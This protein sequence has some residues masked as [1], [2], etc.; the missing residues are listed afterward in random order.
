[1][2]VE[3]FYDCTLYKCDCREI[4][5]TAVYDCIVTDPVW[6]NVPAG[7]F[8]I[9]ES[10]FDLFKTAAEKFRCKRAVVILRWDSD[11]RF[12]SA[13]PERFA[14]LRVI[15]LP[16]NLP[17][18]CGRTLGGME[19]AYAFGQYPAAPGFKRIIPGIAP[20]VAFKRSGGSHPCPRPQAHLDWLVAN[21]ARS[22]EVVCDPF[23]GSG[24]TG[25]AAVKLGRG[26]I[27]AE[28][29]Q[30]YFDE[31]CRNIER[32]QIQPSLFRRQNEKNS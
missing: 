15:N 14:F 16:Y 19:H 30:K 11:P 25:V 23:M 8:E 21:W 13:M 22:D 20:S 1:M 29:N 3:R 24:T 10:P 18:Y 27:G 4:L 5:D 28:I 32:A 6:P 7:M 9:T 26:F 17:N 2:Q 12:L 31:A